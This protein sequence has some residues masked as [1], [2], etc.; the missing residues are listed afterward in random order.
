MLG[1][2]HRHGNRQGHRP[3][4]PRTVSSTRPVRHGS[5]VNTPVRSDHRPPRVTSSGWT[6]P[7]GSL[8]SDAVRRAPTG[9]KCRRRNTV[10]SDMIVSGDCGSDSSV[11]WVRAVRNSTRASPRMSVRPPCTAEETEVI[12]GR[13]PRATSTVGGGIKN[14][15]ASWKP[16]PGPPPGTI[17]G[18]SIHGLEPGTL[19]RAAHHLRP[20]SRAGPASRKSDHRAGHTTGPA[21]PPGRPSDRAG[22]STGPARSPDRPSDR[23]GHGGAGSK[24]AG[25]GSPSAMD[26]RSS[27]CAG[28]GVVRTEVRNPRS[29][30]SR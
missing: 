23:T 12:N 4:G 29:G 17:S 1:A 13:D 5:S 28:P 14:R 15:I 26:P 10:Q 24:T 21:I 20:M 9:L 19:S 2:H 22:H 11:T 8:G 16:V 7:P 30:R 3:L 6:D 18:H 27:D 25:H